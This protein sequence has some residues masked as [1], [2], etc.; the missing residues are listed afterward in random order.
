MAALDFPSSPTLNQVYSANGRSWIWDGSAWNLLG[1]TNS[2]SGPATATDNALARYDGTTGRLI[3]NSGITVS[4]SNEVAGVDSFA[5]DT[6]AG[7]A[8]ASQG[9]MAWNADEE[10]ISVLL[11]GFA[12]NTGQHVLYHVENNTGSTIAKGIPVM[13][14]GTAGNSGKIRI[15][16]WNGTGP[17]VYF[18]GLTAEE[19]EHEDA[20]FV[21]AFG[22]LSGIQTNGSNYG[23]T[24]TNG[25]IIYA[26]TTT[27]SLTN[28]APVAPN[29]KIIVCAVIAD[30][31]SNGTLFIRPTLGSNIKDD[32]GVTITSLTSGQLLV[33]N[34]AG[35]VFE[36]KSVSGD[37]TLA[38]T[39]ALT[40]ANTAV[41]PGAYTNA[42]ITVDAK[43]RIT[44]AANG[45][46]G[47][48]GG[49]TAATSF[50]SAI[51]S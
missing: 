9:Q 10:T 47:G 16:P 42:D 23:Q 36:N 33:A 4:D 49:D 26:G 40:L 48:G 22:K 39:G 17:S 19:L 29:P 8:L 28:T 15:A 30:H 6:T 35:T 41:A 7:V 21:I 45:T 5:F 38:D 18:M 20:G 34:A 14:A 12:M 50:L 32:E 2:V 13:F 37:A 51:W 24:W 31:A 11:N 43:G 27:G 46:G 44:A 3:Q 25:D 1:V